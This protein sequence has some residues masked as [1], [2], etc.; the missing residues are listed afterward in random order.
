MTINDIITYLQDNPQAAQELA[1]R[2]LMPWSS[3][4][5][6]RKRE[7]V[8]G[9]VVAWVDSAGAGRYKI[10]IWSERTGSWGISY[11][12]GDQEAALTAADQI[13]QRRGYVLL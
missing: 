10:E 2:L 12:W 13:L 6:N 7:T 5:M 11:Y 4:F 9:R 3:C 8:S 1:T